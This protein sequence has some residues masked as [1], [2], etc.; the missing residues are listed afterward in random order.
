MTTRNELEKRTE[1]EILTILAP[2][3][4]SAGSRQ[5]MTRIAATLLFFEYDIYPSA[6]TVYRYTQRGSMGDINSDLRKFWQ[7]LRASGRVNLEAP[8]LPDG[9]A[10]RFSAALGEVWTLALAAADATL[11]GEREELVAHEAKIQ[12]KLENAHRDKIAAENAAQSS[13]SD[14]LVERERRET[15]EM[16][17]EA[18]SAEIAALRD[19]LARW[20]ERAAA[21]AIAR[22][23]AEQRF[24]AALDDQIIARK[25]D[26]DMLE[27][28]IK[29]AKLQIDAARGA[30]R[31]LRAR[32]ERERAESV[33][34]LEVLRQKVVRAELAREGA[35]LE[36]ATLKGRVEELQARIK[37]LA[38]D[39]GR[40][41]KTFAILP[42]RVRR[43]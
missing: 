29:F 40:S 33:V 39:R 27:G 24:D 15:A 28:E 34:E 3:L 41:S 20:Q 30:E 31:E 13:Q 1:D 37:S 5:E 19:D 4:A 8:M 11:D 10:G 22:A 7:T 16:K 9:L 23:E 2:R 43:V 18:Q 12:N 42:K 21:D 14:A 36:V 17:G 35:I 32:F 38:K 6:K 26:V 25:R